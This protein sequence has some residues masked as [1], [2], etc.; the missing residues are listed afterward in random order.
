VL[1]EPPSNTDDKGPCP[2]VG[3][4]AGP[5]R[6]TERDAPG[7][8]DYAHHPSCQDLVAVRPLVLSL[9]EAPVKTRAG[10][11][12]DGTSPTRRWACGPVS[13]RRPAPGS[14]PSPTRPSRRRASGACAA[15]KAARC[16]RRSSLTAPASTAPASARTE[17]TCSGHKTRRSEPV[18]VTKRDGANLFRSQTSGKARP[19]AQ[20]SRADMCC[21]L[22]P[23][24]PRRPS[25]RFHH[26][27][28]N[29][30]SA[31]PSQAACKP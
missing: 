11:P 17:R 2:P 5:R 16:C 24:G 19:A 18:Q 21:A 23:A 22:G 13:C 27:T 12:G 9:D 10:L 7:Q 8:W 4:L 1:H 14:G 15:G 6:S 28:H 29:E 25:R 3:K 20:L 26:G 31:R 30:P